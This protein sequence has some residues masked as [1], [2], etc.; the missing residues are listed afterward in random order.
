MSQQIQERLS[1]LRKQVKDIG[2]GDEA[3]LMRNLDAAGEA[4]QN[5][6]AIEAV[7]AIPQVQAAYAA[8][9]NTT[10]HLA[11][12]ILF[13]DVT[14]CNPNFL[15][16]MVF[17]F[18]ACEKLRASF[19]PDQSQEIAKEL[20]ESVQAAVEAQKNSPESK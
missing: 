7:A 10:N 18:Q 2:F 4:Y 5:A 20:E 13:A 11:R 6:M 3:E 17:Q 8:I 9:E 15:L 12:E 19:L 1:Q 14:K 16:S